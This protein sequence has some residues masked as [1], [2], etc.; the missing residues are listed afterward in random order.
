MGVEVAQR[1][2]RWQRGGSEPPSV[3]ASTG[4]EAACQTLLIVAIDGVFQEERSQ[5]PNSA[6]AKRG[7]CQD[8]IFD[9][10]RAKASRSTGEEKGENGNENVPANQVWAAALPSDGF[11]TG[12]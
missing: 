11:A 12:W 10:E 5:Q 2:T 6:T 8:M 1:P 7:K 9:G 3:L 4:E